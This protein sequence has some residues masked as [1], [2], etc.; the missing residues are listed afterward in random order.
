MIE[1]YRDNENEL[2][3]EKMS[4]IRIKQYDIIPDKIKIV[5]FDKGFKNLNNYGICIQ[6]KIYNRKCP[7]CQSD[8]TYQRELYNNIFYCNNC[9]EEFKIENL[10]E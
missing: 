9:K 6:D 5:L 1:L 3:C 2:I 4:Y 8:E 7:F 10:Y